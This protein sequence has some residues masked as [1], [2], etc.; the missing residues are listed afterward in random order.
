LGAPKFHVKTLNFHCDSI[1][2]GAMGSDEVMK[3][4]LMT[5]LVHLRGSS[6]RSFLP[7]LYYIQISEDIRLQPGS[8][9]TQLFW[10]LNLKF[11]ASKNSKK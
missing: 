10:H 3:Y 11:T 8:Q 5:G 6:L 9:R 1:R 7:S 4:S 2:R